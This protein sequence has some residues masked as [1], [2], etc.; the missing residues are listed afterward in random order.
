MSSIPSSSASVS[1]PRAIPVNSIL[2]PYDLHNFQ[3]VEEV[4]SRLQTAF[5]KGIDIDYSPSNHCL[6]S[7]G[8]KEH[9]AAYELAKVFISSTSNASKSDLNSLEH[10]KILQTALDLTKVNGDWQKV[11]EKRQTLAFEM[12]TIVNEK[13]NDRR[14]GKLPYAER[15]VNVVNRLSRIRS[16]APPAVRI[17][18]LVIA[19]IGKEKIVDFIAGKEKKVGSC[20]E[21]LPTADKGRAFTQLHAKEQTK[22]LVEMCDKNDALKQKVQELDNVIQEEQSQRNSQKPYDVAKQVCYAAADVA[23]RY[24]NMNRQKAQFSQQRAQLE[25]NFRN[26]MEC[27]KLDANISQYSDSLPAHIQT[28]FS[29]NYFPQ[30]QTKIEQRACFSRE[31]KDSLDHFHQKMEKCQQAVKQGSLNIDEG[32]ALYSKIHSDLQTK[33]KD[34]EQQH[35]HWEKWSLVGNIITQVTGIALACFTANPIFLK[36]SAIIQGVSALGNTGLS[37]GANNRLDQR[38]AILQSASNLDG[39]AQSAFGQEQHKVLQAQH[40]HHH[41]SS[42]RDS[43][44]ISVAKN[45]DLYIAKERRKILKAG[46]TTLRSEVQVL[47]DE[48]VGLKRENSSLWGKIET[49]EGKINRIHTKTYDGPKK[50]E[51]KTK[52]DNNLI[53]NASGELILTWAETILQNKGIDY[54]T[55]EIQL[56]K[57]EIDELLRVAKD[58]KN[59]YPK[60]IKASQEARDLQN[61]VKDKYKELISTSPENKTKNTQTIIDK[62]EFLDEILNPAKKDADLTA[63]V[64][65]YGEEHIPDTKSKSAKVLDAIQK[66]QNELARKHSESERPVDLALQELRALGHNISREFGYNLPQSLAGLST[67]IYDIYKHNKHMKDAFAIMLEGAKSSDD[68]TIFSILTEA[69]KSGNLIVLVSTFLPAVQF[70]NALFGLYHF[71]NAATPRHNRPSELQQ[72]MDVLHAHLQYQ[73]TIIDRSFKML[74]SEIKELKEDLK[75]VFEKAHT[76]TYEN[77]QR[78]VQEVKNAAADSLE[79][80]ITTKINEFTGRVHTKC[81]HFKDGLTPSSGG[82]TFAD[83]I[84]DRREAQA[85]TKL[86]PYLRKIKNHLDLT[87]DVHN[88]GQ[89]NIGVLPSNSHFFWKKVIIDPTY[90]TGLLIELTS[91]FKDTTKNPSLPLF[92][93]A[94]HVFSILVIRCRYDNPNILMGKKGDIIELSDTFLKYTEALELLV[95]HQT[96]DKQIER[97]REHQQALAKTLSSQKKKTLVAKTK[98]LK[99]I[100]SDRAPLAHLISCT[101]EALTCAEGRFLLRKLVAQKLLSSLL[102][103]N[104][105]PD[106]Y[107]FDFVAEY[108][109]L[110]S[111]RAKKFVLGLL[112]SGKLCRGVKSEQQ[113]E[114]D[115]KLFESSNS[116]YYRSMTHI[117]V[118][119]AI[120]TYFISF[121]PVMLPLRMLCVGSE[122]DSNL[123]GYSSLDIKDQLSHNFKHLSQPW[124]DHEIK[125][126]DYLKYNSVELD[127]SYN[128]SYKGYRC[129]RLEMNTYTDSAQW[130]QK[131]REKRL[132]SWKGIDDITH[133]NAPAKSLLRF[134]ISFIYHENSVERKLQVLGDEGLLQTEDINHIPKAC[135]GDV[136]FDQYSDRLKSLT[137]GYG[138]C[139]LA[140]RDNQS[141]ASNHLFKTIQDTGSMIP[142]ADPKLLPLVIPK[143]TLQACEDKFAMDE[144]QMILTGLGRLIPQYEFTSTSNGSYKLSLTYSAMINGNLK[145]YYRFDIAT[146][147][148]TTVDTFRTVKFSGNKYDITEPDLNQCLIQMLYAQPENGVG[149][150]GAGSYRIKKGKLV[151]PQDRPCVGFYKHLQ[152]HPNKQLKFRSAGLTAEAAPLFY[153]IDMPFTKT[154]MKQYHLVVGAM[155]DAGQTWKK[156]EKYKEYETQYLMTVAHHRLASGKS[157]IAIKNTFAKDHHLMDPKS[158]WLH[159]HLDGINRA[160]QDAASSSAATAATPSMPASS[161]AA[162]AAAAPSMPASSFAPPTVPSQSPLQRLLAQYKQNFACIKQGMET[163]DLRVIAEGLKVESGKPFL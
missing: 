41:A 84:C 140:M 21:D 106:K 59:S 68:V 88:N 44:L 60:R 143:E 108:K 63:P 109:S 110:D 123:K 162:A 50:I 86:S 52:K 155:L 5:D 90:F 116:F 62:Q 66:K 99:K 25:R 128:N 27:F 45:P 6:P 77:Q 80:F 64:D 159:N 147:D 91:P 29:S 117:A 65:D 53:M 82:P 89:K 107:N 83:F 37:I 137:K 46:V 131:Y 115:L 2:T 58:P 149:L 28:H 73:Q 13:H 104:N 67:H 133:Q 31:C 126:A 47:E 57:N 154:R 54:L 87:S 11:P 121:L 144:N 26:L 3:L 69:V 92:R 55:P 125:L 130:Y 139:L 103:K 136:A 36:T 30:I 79:T 7:C 145:G 97:T 51:T 102:K 105:N 24:H 134:K 1:R 160:L 12:A 15:A 148:K 32:K 22:L 96:L 150:P 112:H 71:L 151:A 16:K 132:I 70:A 4:D 114:A 135:S 19:A 33:I 95:S 72:Q 78:I 158:A 120:T 124:T 40:A 122:Q 23:Q 101:E 142:P 129:R 48:D 74:G 9:R 113:Q 75:E 141:L 61:E 14:S 35:A 38:Q 152:D 100:N 17:I 18:P 85:L 81:E 146:V 39:V 98:Q 56:Q 10:Q 76:E 127:G 49:E 161:S 118:N 138:E 34:F 20:P 153:V 8:T 93:E 163:D 43:V 94:A 156:T 111:E 157:S 119:S 42:Q